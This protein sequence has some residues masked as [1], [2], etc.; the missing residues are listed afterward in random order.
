M[1]RLF[2]AVFGLGLLVAPAA[3]AWECYVDPIYERNWCGRYKIAAYV[4]EREC[5]GT[6]KLETVAAGTVVPIIAE[7]DGWYK[8]KTNKG[9]IGWT[10]ATLMEVVDCSLLTP[11]TTPTT[12]TNTTSTTTTTTT[13]TSSGSFNLLEHTKGRMLLAV[14]DHGKI[15]YVSPV[16]GKRYQATVDNALPLFRSLALGI[17]NADLN[18]LPLYGG[19]QHRYNMELRNRIKGRLLLAVED[20]GRV[21]YVGKDDTWRREVTKENIMDVF[22]AHSLGISNVD[23]A[24]IPIG[25]VNTSEVASNPA[26]TTPV[27]NTTSTSSEVVSYDLPESGIATPSGWQTYSGNGFNFAYPSTW[28]S[29]T[30]NIYPNWKYFSEEAD[31]IANLNT[32]NYLDVDSYALA[33]KVGT[34]VSATLSDAEALKKGGYYLTGYNIIET[35][36]FII[37]GMPALRELLYAPRG[38]TVNGSRVTGENEYIILYTYRSGT[39][40]YRL[41]YFS[42]HWQDRYNFSTFDQMA[43]TFKLN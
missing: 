16:T 11:S 27:S 42:A 4:L 28:L 30:K 12:T 36:V 13:S 33:Y 34:S 9:N 7:T 3:Q 39:T 24:K 26:P 17:T 25:D 18:K 2:L 37:N 22:R 23:L 35:D 19:V 38:T 15:W 32:P 29:G 14:E 8:V 43:K 31:Y 41:Q 10:G 5:S 40:L 21:W 20:H 1:F 6:P